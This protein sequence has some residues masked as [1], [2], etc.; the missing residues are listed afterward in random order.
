MRLLEER[1]LDGLWLTFFMY[2]AAWVVTFP[3]AYRAFSRFAASPGWLVVLMLSA[4]WTNIA[5][6]EAILDGKVLRVLL[7]FYLSPLWAA[8]MGRLLLGE[9][10]SSLA[11]ASLA[12]ALFG[13]LVMLWDADGGFPWPESRADWLALTSGF[14][15]ALS[16][17]ATRATPQV[18]VVLKVFGVWTGVS[19]MAL[20]IVFVAGMS[21]PSVGYA[22]IGGAVA[23]GIFG[24]LLMTSLIQYGVTHL[25]VY[26]S[27][28]ITFVELVAGAISQALLTS[29]AMLIREWVGGALIVAGAYLAARASAG[30]AK[31]Q[32]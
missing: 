30:F 19:V 24:I 23:L 5:F 6:V 28:I 8:L 11:W 4:G 29:E 27:A 26:R 2:A 16:N 1:G 14:A 25:P 3:F 13:A 18:P 10:I 22:T 15:F 20:A 31:D 12:I 32:E 7:L 21:M 9:R 17:V